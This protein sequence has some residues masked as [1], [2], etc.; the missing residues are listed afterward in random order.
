[1]VKFGPAAFRQAMNVSRETLAR[2]EAYAALLIRHQAKLNLVA[3]STLPDL[4]HRHMLDS[5]QLAGLAPT[6]ARHWVDFGSGA[7]FP[8][9][10]VAIMKSGEP[11]F[12][13]HL[14]ERLAAKCAFLDE[15]IKETGAPVIV[16]RGRIEALDPLAGQVITARACA[17]L[18]ELLPLFVRHR[19]ADGIGLFAKGRNASQEL[20]QAGG[21]WRLDLD[22][23]PSR[24]GSG[25]QILRIRSAERR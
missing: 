21:L 15:V 10:V 22:T 12:V 2:L 18:I 9:L 6:V 13:M 1:M 11:G 23:L 5:A 24:T 3:A 8:G 17:P 4:W 25:G 19:A 7:G 14:T 20:T 16:H